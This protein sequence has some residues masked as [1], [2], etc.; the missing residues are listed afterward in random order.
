[1]GSNDL[2]RFPVRIARSGSIS[3]HSQ[4]YDEDSS[5]EHGRKAKGSIHPHAFTPLWNNRR[6]LDLPRPGW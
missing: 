3:S 4:I 6:N 5:L 1:M 2:H